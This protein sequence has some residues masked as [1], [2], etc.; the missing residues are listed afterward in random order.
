MCNENDPVLRCEALD[1]LWR[2]DP[3]LAILQIPKYLSADLQ[4]VR[5]V[6]CEVLEDI[7]D[8]STEHLLLNHLVNE[9]EPTVR[10]AAVAALGAVGTRNSIPILYN[11]I[12]SDQSTDYEG[13]QIGDLA[14]EVIQLINARD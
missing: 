3:K 8:F 1:L 7:A 5:R 2:V 9:R 10:Y 4:A 13:R 6:A 14:M 12:Q 11:I